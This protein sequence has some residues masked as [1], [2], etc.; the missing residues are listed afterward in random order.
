MPAKDMHLH[1][2]NLDLG[3]GRPRN[4]QAYC[5]TLTDLSLMEIAVGCKFESDQHYEYIQY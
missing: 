2:C 1:T 3:F 4:L 5:G